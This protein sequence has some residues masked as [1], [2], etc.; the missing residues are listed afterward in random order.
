MGALI[1]EAK[2]EDCESIA[3]VNIDT[4]R[5][6]YRGIMPDHV[7]AALSYEEVANNYRRSLQN[8]AARGLVGLVAQDALGEVVGLAWAGRT[9]DPDPDHT[10]EIRILYVLDTHQ[11][12]GIGRSL[13]QGVAL[14]LITLGH[15]SLVIWVLKA[16][17]RARLFYEALGGRLSDERMRTLRGVALEEV[18]YDWYDLSSLAAD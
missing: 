9:W 3:R 14:R 13:V 17:H 6:A 11:R 8:S 10:A 1:R 2:P 15:S 4:W 5:T 12:R 16:N 7:L 18:A